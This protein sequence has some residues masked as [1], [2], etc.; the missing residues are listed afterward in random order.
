MVHANFQKAECSAGY[1]SKSP[2]A[3]VQCV[4]FIQRT[5]DTYPGTIV[6]PDEKTG[7]LQKLKRNFCIVPH[8]LVFM[9]GVNKHKVPSAI[10]SEKSNR[11]VSPNSCT[12]L[13][14]LPNFAPI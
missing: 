6:V 2:E 14:M 3:R 12:T 4:K 9:A 13:E 10:P 11:P 7:G 5:C 8:I 1:V